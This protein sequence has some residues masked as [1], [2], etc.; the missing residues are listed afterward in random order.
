VIQVAL[1]FAGLQNNKSYS[2][3]GTASVNPQ[4]RRSFIRSDRLIT[5]LS[6]SVD[7]EVEIPD[8]EDAHLQIPLGDVHAF[9]FH[10]GTNLK[11]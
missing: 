1:A 10:N 4:I 11:Y 7:V 8:Q 9:P 3:D 2:L 6:S 5:M